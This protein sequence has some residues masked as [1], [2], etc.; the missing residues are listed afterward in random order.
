MNMILASVIALCLVLNICY[1]WIYPDWDGYYLF[2]LVFI[3][4]LSGALF[5]KVSYKE[6]MLKSVVFAVFLDAIW[7]IGQFFMDGA[8]QGP[9][10]LLNAII[11]LPWLAYAIRRNY[12]KPQ[13]TIS[14]GMIYNLSHKPKNIWGFIPSIFTGR[15][16]YKVLCGNAVYGFSKGEYFVD[17]YADLSGYK[18]SDTGIKITPA[19]EHYLLSKEGSEWHWYDNCVTMQ[20]KLK[21]LQWK[22]NVQA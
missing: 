21:Y 5:N 19:I 22:G 12:D 11:F 17:A 1:E 13:S 14:Q 4:V 15:A 16:G 3:A 20:F 6:L 2:K 7:N 18:V 10:E 8:W 9:L